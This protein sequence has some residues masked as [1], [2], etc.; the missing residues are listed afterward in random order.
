MIVAFVIA[1]ILAFVRRPH[2]LCAGRSFNVVVMSQLKYDF[3][4]RN[5]QY[6]LTVG[7]ER[8]QLQFHDK[9]LDFGSASDLMCQLKVHVPGWQLSQDMSFD[10]I[11]RI[12]D[13]SGQL[14]LVVKK[15]S[16]L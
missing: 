7:C 5:V 4:V 12:P 3:M 11:A 14:I 6:Q 1:S 8:Y 10:E 13:Y 2:R 15:L 16:H 9:V